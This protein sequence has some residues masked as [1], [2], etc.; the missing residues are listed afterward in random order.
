MK[1]AQP[2]IS[3][4][5]PM[6][7]VE[8]YLRRCLDSVLNQTFQNWQAICV[9]DG[10]P[11]NSGIIAD[12][13]AARDKRFVVIHKKNGGVSSARNIGLK[14]AR[15]EYIMF[16]DSDDCLHHQAMEIVYGFANEY[17]VDIVSFA[18][19]KKMYKSITEGMDAAQLI[20]LYDSEHYDLKNIKHKKTDNLI[21]FATE[22]N[23][24]AG[25]WKIRHCYPVVH[26]YKR[27]LLVGISFDE[28]IKISEDFPFW[29]A[30]LLRNPT[31]VILKTPLYF[32][33]P[34]MESALRAADSKKVFDNVTMATERA[35]NIVKS[36]QPSNEWYRVWAR[37]FLWPFVI[38]F[39][40]SFQY[41]NAAKRL[42][43][44]MSRQGIFDSPQTLRAKKYK[45]RIERIISQIS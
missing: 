9:D 4:I 27:D 35:F 33:I 36:S 7:N 44:N 10:S 3:I 22:R 26:M 20:K 19:N 16:L 2:K 15:G 38:I 28:N 21:E 41:S 31:G 14:H 11:D 32:Y 45:H 37:E 13:Y 39:M 30:V 23:H 43:A 25:V 1:C 40:R 18:H 6:Y 29:T 34:N 8:K 24:T 12:E 5:I 17:G 42:L